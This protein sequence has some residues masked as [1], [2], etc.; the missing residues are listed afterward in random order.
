MSRCSV[1]PILATLMLIVSCGRIA[2][3]V[4]PKSGGRPYEVC[5]Y[6]ND[7]ACAAVVDSLLSQSVP[8]LPQSE[9]QFDVVIVKE[10]QPCGVMR[11][12]RAILI[13]DENPSQYMTTS[14]KYEKNVWA[15]PQIVVY[16]NTPSVA[17]LTR[18]LERSGGSITGLLN[19]FEMNA[20]ISQMDKNALNDVAREVKRMSG[21]DMVIPGE[22]RI[23]KTGRDFI[24]LS[25]NGAEMA[26]NICLYSY[27]AKDLDPK[28]AA[29][30][31]DSIMAVNMK[32]EYDGMYVTTKSGGKA[33]G[34]IKSGGRH[35]MVG[36]GLWQME[37]DA[38]G[39]P[40]V[41]VSLLDTALARMTVA[42]AFVYAPGLEKRNIIRRLEAVL[43]TMRKTDK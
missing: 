36:R 43:Y 34:L 18:S 25:N 33:Y 42:E 9:R 22:L 1:I 21:Y 14:V 17:A 39:G 37:G 27:P 11:Y 19:R 30:V 40:F 4:L 28:R 10:Q 38:M 23:M 16:I 20:A 24:W 15:H 3:G 31:R 5:L 26:E 6:A 12:A 41:T 8:W 7:T 2:R 32:G 35:I 29:F 13:V